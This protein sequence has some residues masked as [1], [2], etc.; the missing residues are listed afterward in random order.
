M[1]RLLAILLLLLPVS[2]MAWNG[3]DPSW[4]PYPFKEGK[5]GIGVVTKNPDWYTVIFINSGW[6]EYV[7]PANQWVTINWAQ[8]G[9]PNDAIAADIGGNL[10]ITHGSKQPGLCYETVTFD[11]E[12]SP[13]DPGNFILESIDIFPQSGQR[14]GVFVRVPIL[15]G[16]TRF[17]WRRGTTSG[18][19]PDGTIGV[20]P[21]DCAYGVNLSIEG[22]IR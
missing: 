17:M 15:N 9:V 18:S 22:Y 19:Y 2:A 4:G 13:V 5:S 1:A 16:Q 3:S 6:P 12:G 14:E 21:D 8:F 7:A 20:W 11:V 10:S